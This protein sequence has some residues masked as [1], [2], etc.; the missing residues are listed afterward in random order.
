[1]VKA[2]EGMTRAEFEHEM[3]VLQLAREI[4]E[5]HGTGDVIAAVNDLMKGRT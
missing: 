5:S 3:S 2:P 1:M 4:Y